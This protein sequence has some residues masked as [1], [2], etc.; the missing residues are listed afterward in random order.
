[1]LTVSMN[2]SRFLCGKRWRAVACAL[3]ANVELG[4]AWRC[5]GLYVVVSI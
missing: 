2:T 5:A 3:P 1:L 4:A